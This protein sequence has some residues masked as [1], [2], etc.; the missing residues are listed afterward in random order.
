MQDIH[1]IRPPVQVGFDPMVIKTILLVS[2]GI[3][4][5]VLLFFL[6]KKYFKKR[7]Q[8]KD[9]KYLPEPMAPYESALKELELLF[10]SRVLDPR[11]FYFDLIAVLKKY[12]G[13]SYEINAV[14]MTSQEF[15][16]G[17]NRLNLDQ[18]AKKDI[19]GFHERSDP[20]R[21]AGIVPGKDRAKEDLLFIKETIHQIE[22]GLIRLK[23]KKEESP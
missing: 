11:L 16:K 3:I 9:L 23:K 20:I 21:Y 13:R 8:P 1:D 4:L 22:K 12:I 18:V 17:I 14:E 10:Q 2:G 6:I 7:K 5:L 19:A 15:I